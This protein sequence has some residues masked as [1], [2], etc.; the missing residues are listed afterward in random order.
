MSVNVEGNKQ[1]L[2][3]ILMIK[4]VIYLQQKQL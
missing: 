4:K 2:H 3:N 1:S